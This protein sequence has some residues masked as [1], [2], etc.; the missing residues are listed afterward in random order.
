MVI[1]EHIKFF[2]CLKADYR[3]GL[4]VSTAPKSRTFQPQINTYSIKKKKKTLETLALIK[5]MDDEKVSKIKALLFT[6]LTVSQG[7]SISLI[8]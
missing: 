1:L 5:P 7:D 3:F 2:S 4:S 8:K 6:G